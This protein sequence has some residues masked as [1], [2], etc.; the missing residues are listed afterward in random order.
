MS[1]KSHIHEDVMKQ[2]E[3]EHITMR[4]KIYFLVG[5]LLVGAGIAGAVITSVFF[6]HITLYRLQSDAVFDY[7]DFGTSGVQSFMTSFPWIP[8]IIAV[9]GLLWGSYLLHEYEMP[10]KYRYKRVI[11]IFIAILLTSGYLL[12][13]T[14]IRAHMMGYKPLRPWYGYENQRRPYILGRVIEIHKDGAVIMTPGRK[15]I[16]IRMQ[17]LK[18]NPTFVKGALIKALGAWEE[19][20]FYIQHLRVK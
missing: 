4:P 6:T 1:D 14:G 5:S 2:I 3:K 17:A 18:D 9:F 11:L 8:F 15:K 13:R 7:L 10:A 19:E 16:F 20:V 12:D